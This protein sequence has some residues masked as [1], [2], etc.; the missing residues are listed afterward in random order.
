VRA[1]N[2]VASAAAAYARQQRDTQAH[3]GPGAG[4]GDRRGQAEGDVV[5]SDPVIL[6]TQHGQESERSF[7]GPTQVCVGFLA[8]AMGVRYG[9]PIT[10]TST[11]CADGKTSSL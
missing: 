5:D 10:P 3:H 9:K 6:F 1:E 2:T 7:T 4:F 8:A 11:A